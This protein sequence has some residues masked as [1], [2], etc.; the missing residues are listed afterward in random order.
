MQG[1]GIVIAGVI[2]IS[3]LLLFVSIRK[4]SSLIINFVL[5]GILGTIAIYLTNEALM[6]QEIGCFVG[7]NPLTVLTSASLGF[8]GVLLLYGIKLYSIL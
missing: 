4:N 3:I 8:P 1:E 6:W 2:V 7:I 5:R